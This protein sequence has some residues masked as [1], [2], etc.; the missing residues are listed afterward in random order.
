MPRATKEDGGNA[1]GKAQ[2]LDLPSALAFPRGRSKEASGKS[3]FQP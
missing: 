1:D 3:L 2:G